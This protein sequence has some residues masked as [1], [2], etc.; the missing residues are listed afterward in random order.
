MPRF[1]LITDSPAHSHACH[2]T[3]DEIVALLRGPCGYSDVARCIEMIEAPTKMSEGARGY[4]QFPLHPAPWGVSTIHIEGLMD[5]E[6]ERFSKPCERCQT[7]GKPCQH[8]P[9]IEWME[10]GHRCGPACA[11]GQARKPGPGGRALAGGFR[12]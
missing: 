1:I 3:R 12:R 5:F 2:V 9:A 4:M 11:L 6:R 10:T 7:F 8:R